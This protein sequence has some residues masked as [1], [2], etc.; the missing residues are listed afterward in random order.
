MD[1]PVLVN[2]DY[3][4]P[5]VYIGRSSFWGNPYRIAGGISRAE[6]L[7]AFEKYVRDSELW[8]K[9]GQLTGKKLV[10]PGACCPKPCHGDV[11]VKLWKEKFT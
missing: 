2:N 4:G 10:C 3:V 5:V 7:K 6:A 11:L 9:L 8:D 1:A